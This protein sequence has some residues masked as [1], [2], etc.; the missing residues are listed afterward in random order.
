MDTISV[1]VP[2]YNSETYLPQCIQSILAQTYRNIDVIVVDDGSVDTSGI[3]CDE[4]A[5]SDNR[6]RVIHTEN[7]GALLA[8]MTGVKYARG[9]YF[10][11]IDSDDWIEEDYLEC[12]IAP[13]GKYDIDISVTSYCLE[14]SNKIPWIKFLQADSGVL[15]FQQALR[16]MFEGIYFDWA[17]HGKLYKK[18]LFDSPI[19]WHTNISYGED[20]EVNWYLFQRAQK[21]FYAPMYLY[22]YRMHS[23]SLMHQKFTLDR[24]AYLDRLL[25]ILEQIESKDAPLREIFVTLL[26]FYGV[27]YLLTMLHKD[28]DLYKE[29]IAYYQKQLSV[30]DAFVSRKIFSDGTYRTHKKLSYS[31]AQMSPSEFLADCAKREQALLE[32]V[33]P[34]FANH[35]KVYIYGTGIIADEVAQIIET[36]GLPY[37][38]FVVSK[39]KN[40][41][42]RNYMVFSFD[43]ALALHGEEFALL[44]AMNEKNVNDVLTTNLRDRRIK[45]VNAGEYSLRY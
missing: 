45:I 39:K 41:R 36:H 15:D 25:M 3:V 34:L 13:F 4:Y 6:V 24:L 11:F 43:E 40:D 30:Y 27:T 17:F 18:S 33:R 1:V 26:S 21:I 5:K 31:S 23:D 7:Q 35:L 12:L 32:M 29:H 37:E 44:L 9:E 42:F 10:C 38:G 16:W 28:P 14:E 20:T 22:H 8:R 19:H 2:V